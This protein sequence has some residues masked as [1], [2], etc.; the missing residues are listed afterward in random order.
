MNAYMDQIDSEVHKA[1]GIVHA[2]RQREPDARNLAAIFDIDGTLL[3]EDSRPIGPVVQLYKLCQQLGYVMFIVTAR[4]SNGISETIRQL[5]ASGIDGFH[6]VYFRSPS[7]WNI[8]KFKR[9]SRVSI[10]TGG[11][12]PVICIGDTD[13]DMPTQTEFDTSHG[14]LLPQLG[15]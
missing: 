8:G 10:A 5:R 11:F 15:F 12:K 13:W 14:I 2:Y 6:S 4:D 7:V 9:A 3:L 1:I